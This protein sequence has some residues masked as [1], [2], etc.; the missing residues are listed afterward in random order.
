MLSQ[1]QAEYLIKLPKLILENDDLVERKEYNYSL[2]LND[3]I[4]LGSK[5]DKDFSF[6]LDITQSS[7]KHIKL[8]LHFQENGINIGLLRVDFNGRHRNPDNIRGGVPNIFKPYTGKWIEESHIHYYIEG[9]KP[10]SWA[11]PLSIDNSF[12]IKNFDGEND[13]IQ[14]IQAFG[15]KITLQTQL[16]IFIQTRML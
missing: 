6:F 14:I 10:L 3:R 16:E 15:E 7:K 13:V 12:P 8:T 4:Y 11:I 9:Y 5:D 2:P 1:E